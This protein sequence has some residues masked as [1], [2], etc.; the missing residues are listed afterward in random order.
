[1]ISDEL[2]AALQACSDQAGLS[3]HLDRLRRE[4]SLAA[5]E[6]QQTMNAV[7]AEQRDVAALES[8]SPTRIWATLR[9]THSSDLER[10]SA[11]LAA[12][13]FRA[14]LAATVLAAA[15]AS[16][17]QVEATLAALGDVEARRAAALEAEEARLLGSEGSVSA[18]LLEVSEQLSSLRTQL[19]EV[20]QALAA[21]NQA[22]QELALTAELL[23][24]AQGWGA[25]D[26]FLGGGLLT[27]MVKYERID[28][29]TERLRA[30][31]TALKRFAAELDDVGLEAVNEVE[32]TGLD[33]T[34]DVWF[35]NIFSDWSVLDRIT[36]ATERTQSAINAVATA[37]QHLQQRKFELVALERTLSHA[38]ERLILDR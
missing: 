13:Q 1:M 27:D 20:N 8:L 38:R 12:Q 19:A 18:Q 5:A 15:T 17:E 35:D 9:G 11:E 25:F 14:A 22:Q 37:A 16:R 30:A 32:L 7:Q 28:A 29:A 36:Q 34:F 2:E 33:R 24:S 23:G 10:E 21:G 3:R 4:E 26:V 6:V 31:N